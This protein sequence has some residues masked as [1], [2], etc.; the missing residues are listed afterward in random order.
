MTR[1]TVSNVQ[2]L[3]IVRASLIDNVV[4]ARGEKCLT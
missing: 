1:K 2:A 3:W 4:Q